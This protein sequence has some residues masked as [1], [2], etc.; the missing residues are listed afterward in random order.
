MYEGY[1]EKRIIT[2]FELDEIEEINSWLEGSEFAALSDK[3]KKR[4]RFYQWGV[5]KLR[6]Q[7]QLDNFLVAVMFFSFLISFFIFSQSFIYF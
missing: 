3:E 1:V 4:Y 7:P 6:K 2:A 5:T